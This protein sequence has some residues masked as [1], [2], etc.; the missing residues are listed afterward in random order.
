LPRDVAESAFAS[1]PPPGIVGML[2]RSALQEAFFRQLHGGDAGVFGLLVVRALRLRELELLLGHAMVESLCEAVHAQLGG[3]LRPDDEVVRI[4]EC[5]FAVL[6][7]RLRERNH[8]A[9]AASKVARGLNGMLDVGGRPIRANF[10][11]GAATWPA[12]ADSFETLCLHADQACAAAANGRERFALFAGSAHGRLLEYN[13]LHAALAGNQLALHLQPI[14][15]IASGALVGFEALSRWD[16]P[17]LGPVLPAKFVGLAEQ[18][19]LIGELTR[20]TLNASLRHCAQWLPSHPEASVSV[21]V[22]P[23]AFVD[24][25]LVEQIASALEIWEVPPR[26]LTVEVTENAFAGDATAIADGLRTLHG[27]GVGVAI[28]DFGTGYSSFSYLKRFPVSEL[29]I[30]IEFVADIARDARSAQLS[31]SMVELAHSLGAVAVA[32]G[33]EHAETLERLRELGCDQA[34][35]YFLGRPVPAEEAV[36]ALGAVPQELVPP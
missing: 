8:A 33:V 31:A 26:A 32:E 21:N 22:S 19:G 34:Q 12:D 27:M 7:P 24:Q 20:W 35:G 28:D 11:V 4:G 13:E 23:L 30:D 1:D 2:N 6:L 18:T 29:K 17:R 5:D 25:P 15:D 14:H 36:A 9:L 16:N 3:L 10:A